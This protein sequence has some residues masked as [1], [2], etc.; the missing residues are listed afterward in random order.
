MRSLEG[1]ASKTGVP[2]PLNFA[3]KAGLPSLRGFASKTGVPSP[4]NFAWKAGVPSPTEPTRNMGLPSLVKPTR[5]TGAPSPV[6]PTGEGRASVTGEACAR[7]S[8]SSA[9]IT[10]GPEVLA[11]LLCPLHLLTSEWS[12]G[13]RLSLSLVPS[14]LLV[15]DLEEI[16]FGVSEQCHR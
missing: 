1:F 3:W 5:K 13:G 14:E 15:G 9:G 7:G 4:L 2:S 16:A 12:G 8:L 6:R 10:V 11:R